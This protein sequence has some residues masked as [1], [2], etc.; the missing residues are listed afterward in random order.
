MDLKTKHYL[1]ELPK[2]SQTVMKNLSSTIRALALVDI[3]SPEFSLA[4][5]NSKA[6]NLE[7]ERLLRMQREVIRNLN[8]SYSRRF[9]KSDRYFFLS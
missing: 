1:R 4:L 6:A 5:R 3:N 8:C 9:G 2:F 7:A